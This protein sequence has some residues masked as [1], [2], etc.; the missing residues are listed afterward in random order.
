ME[1]RHASQHS[2]PAPM[3]HSE[4][5]LR[6]MMRIPRSRP[7]VWVTILLVAGAMMVGT[8]MLATSVEDM[9]DAD[10]E[11][12]EEFAMPGS[13][14]KAVLR[15]KRHLHPGEKPGTMK[16]N[17]K[18]IVAKVPLNL[19][20]K[21]DVGKKPGTDTMVDE[22]KYAFY[23]TMPYRAYMAALK[24]LAIKP[25]KII[26]DAQLIIT[27]GNGHRDLHRKHSNLFKRGKIIVSTVLGTAPAGGGKELQLVAKRL[28]AARGGCQYDTFD[29]QPGTFSVYDEVE[30]TE[31]DRMLDSPDAYKQMWIIKPK[32]GEKGRGISVVRGDDPK[33]ATIHAV[34]CA[35]MRE[36]RTY[37]IISSNNTDGVDELDASFG[38]GK[39]LGG[40]ASDSEEDGQ[41]R[42]ALLSAANTSSLTVEELMKIVVPQRR[43]RSNHIVQKYITNPL[44][45]FGTKFDM[46]SY[47]LI[48]CTHPFVV[49]YRGGYVRRAMAT[50]NPS[51]LNDTQSHLT[52]THVQESQTGYNGS[53]HVWSMEKLQTYL[54]RTYKDVVSNDF[55]ES[56][57]EKF[58]K[59]MA[60]VIFESARP[61]IIRERGGFQ[62]IGMD[63]MMDANLQ[64]Q[65]IEANGKPGFGYQNRW[66]TQFG[67][68]FGVD[69]FDLVI[70]LNSD[71][72]VIPR[73]KEGRSVNGFEVLY[74]E[75][76]DDCS[77]RID[78]P[79]APKPELATDACRAL[80]R[81][82]ELNSA[83]FNKYI[84]ARGA[85][86][87]E[88]VVFLEP[89]RARV[90]PDIGNVP[91]VE[92][93]AAPNSNSDG[94]SDD[95]D[96]GAN[97]D[98]DSGANDNGANGNADNGAN[99]DADR[100]A[101]SGADDADSGAND[102]G[103]NGNADNGANGDADRG[104]DSGA[105]DADSGAN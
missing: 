44:L 77:G 34:A 23:N 30:C 19:Y 37:D 105:D 93:E 60:M 25:T 65:F 81:M 64:V 100:G 20:V 89:P 86:A 54:S 27:D 4:G 73:L 94:E 38:K 84:Q 13:A 5:R 8:L 57:V 59:K 75:H 17:C 83:V 26:S 40:S 18:P 55:V 68:D 51:M 61:S 103:A 69:M 97:G 82:K 14:P 74:N 98:A 21:R 15:A 87:P 76:I 79:D 41:S 1:Q 72:S 16:Y 92:E 3:R 33:L 104:A 7:R 45:L 56:K 32:S 67:V 62:L 6:G 28:L 49:F 101:D 12:N 9:G 63:F 66:K 36:K 85:P 52:N 91:A 70:T 53:D 88:P 78:S 11:S 2:S 24:R 48:A 29:V 50:Y 22:L 39:I 71:P 35:F 102:N 58:M 99:G 43:G 31:F 42:Q 95:V 80:S 90:K 10:S 46:R 96:S 47:F